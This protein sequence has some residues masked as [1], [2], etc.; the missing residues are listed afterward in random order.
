[1]KLKRIIA[2]LLTLCTI[3]AFAACGDKSEESSDK[4]KSNPEAL[5]WEGY[6]SMPFLQFL[7]EGMKL[8]TEGKASITVSC[9]KGWKTEE[10]NEKDAKDPYTYI[11]EL[12]DNE[13]D[14]YVQTYFFYMDINDN[15]QLKTAGALRNLNNQEYFAN[16]E[17]ANKA[18]EGI[19]G[20]L[21]DGK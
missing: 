13:H 17:E 19:A 3:L 8:E 4:N 15:G 16:A 11:V 6:D 12:V 9:E 21:A 14:Y 5:V 1:M 7:E 20:G 10:L 2:M 18:L